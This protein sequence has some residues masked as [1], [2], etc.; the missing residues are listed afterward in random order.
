MAN[1]HSKPG[2][3]SKRKRHLDAEDRKSL[4]EK[5]ALKK[6]KKLEFGAKLAETHQVKK[7]IAAA[8]TVAIDD[9][10][11]AINRKERSRPK[12]APVAD[13]SVDRLLSGI[14][15][16][17]KLDDLAWS[18]DEDKRESSSES[19]SSFDSESEESVSDPITDMPIEASDS[20]E[21][22][23]LSE[24]EDSDEDDSLETPG[25]GF[26]RRVSFPAT[27]EFTSESQSLLSTLM[28]ET[29]NIIL[30]SEK[31]HEPRVA[32]SC[33]L[34]LTAHMVS[35]LLTKVQRVE[36]NNQK[37]KKL[38]LETLSTTTESSF[39]DQGTNRARVCVL[40]PF[41]SN[42][43]EIVS[44]IFTLLDLSP[45]QV[46]NGENFVEEYKDQDVRNMHAKNWE[47]WR[48]ELF[49]G[50]YDDNNYDDFIV[51]ITFGFG[52]VKLFFPKTA[53]KL[54]HMDMIIASPLAL[55]RIAAEDH[56]TVKKHE[57]QKNDRIDL[58]DEEQGPSEEEDEIAI[59]MDFL[60]SLDMLVVDRAD[61][62]RMQNW[63]NLIDVVAAC[64]RK[65]VAIISTEIDRIEPKFLDQASG[66]FRQTLVICG[67]TNSD[68]FSSLFASSQ[69]PVVVGTTD[70][71]WS[72][73]SLNRALKHGIKQQFFI[74]VS[75]V[76][77]H[78]RSKY[79]KD[80]GGD[81][82]RRLIIVVS[83]D[84]DYA[85][86]RDFLENNEGLENCYLVESEIASH[87]RK[88]KEILKLFKT[89]V[90]RVIVVSERLLWYQRIR[91]LTGAHV[92][93]FGAPVNDS[94]YADILCDVEDAGR[95]TSVCL[96]TPAEVI[97]RRRI[98]GSKNQNG[99][100]TPGKVVVFTS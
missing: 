80:I 17:R 48:R 38:P 42:C 19:S 10:I 25:I 60:S 31:F 37:L 73:R 39:R 66:E 77:D 71:L 69:D 59:P 93:F 98:V 89:G 61:A 74:N 82:I 45:D 76:F 78:F 11:R 90:S 97:A 16:N 53:D 4:L 83:H 5:K 40:S 81:E 14:G 34:G 47:D 9:V 95:C 23:A 29:R 26:H 79:W 20:D 72:G 91:I 57:K 18:S 15:V 96:H 67:S 55:S 64:N 6:Q 41:R 21:S 68:K 63:D 13:I 88:L 33:Y 58:E 44:N 27:V 8:K 65:P 49:K 100:N 35:H 70:A 92:L 3:R 43:F 50:H 2:Q 1:K 51:G 22:S 62:L 99:E 56:K 52:K 87:R 12:L 36:K 46:G 75:D 30:C 85:Q 24:I 94:V 84:Q 7:A 28:S 32:R 54:C 86:L